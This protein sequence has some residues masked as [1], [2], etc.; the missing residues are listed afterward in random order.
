MKRNRVQKGVDFIGRQQKPF[1]VNLVRAASQSFLTY[2]LRQYQPLYILRLGATSFQLGLVN[3]IG[4][5]ARAAIAL[6]S[7]RSADKHG[8]RRLFL[9]G[10]PLMVLGSLLF[11]VA[12]DWRAA[13]SATFVTLLAEGLLMTAC[14]MVCGTYL[15]NEE[16][17]TGKQLCDMLSTL[18]TLVAPMVAAVVIVEFGGLTVEGIRPLY[19]MQILG[20]SLTFLWVYQQYVDTADKKLTGSQSFSKD[21][22]EVFE[23]GTAVKRWLTYTFLSN[24]SMYLSL[25]YL[26]AFVTEIKRADE[27]VL[28]GMT[29]A[30]LLLPIFLAVAV[31]RFADT[32]GRKKSI[33]VTTSLYCLS[34]LLL[35][36][37]RNVTVLLISG[38]LQGFY[39][40]SAVTQGAV[41][42]ELV[43]VSLLGRWYGITNLFSGLAGIIGPVIGG[44]IW[45]AIG[46]NYVFLF[47]ILI[48]VSKLFILWLKVPETLGAT[49][50]IS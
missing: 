40:L 46:P 38:V 5:I 17:A 49:Q 3:S 18:P 2:L 25:V 13:I 41:T 31:G 22:K 30:S 26:P 43:P 12:A 6:P 14:P 4:G 23:K 29:T 20:F 34:V 37:A 21:M 50:R 1:K 28:G 32:H 33:Y 36:Y 19:Y 9:L 27:F 42:A 7:G 39:M 47:I 44:L 16:R 8:I 24:T 35:I 11:A 15:K 48:E 45:S 10:T